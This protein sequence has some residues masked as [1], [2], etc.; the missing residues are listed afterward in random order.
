MS[1]TRD[2]SPE[3]DY[4]EL[5]RRHEEYKARARRPA[6]PVAGQTSEAAQEANRPAAEPK[7]PEIQ[8]KEPVEAP[9]P[10][11]AG[12]RVQPAEEELPAEEYADPEEDYEDGFDPDAEEAPEEEYENPNPF[13]SFIRFFHGVKDK[14]A[15]RHS[16]EPVDGEELPEDDYED[17]DEEVPAK[18]RFGRNRPQPD[19][20][21]AEYDDL[22][23]EE[24]GN[25][26]DVADIQEDMR[27]VHRRAEAAGDFDGED[28]DDAD[29]DGEDF[30]GEQAHGGGF[31]K[32]MRL[33]VTRV[34]DADED[35]DEG[36]EADWDDLEDGGDALY[37]AG[38][39]PA[40][41]G[42]NRQV[43]SDIEGGQEMDEMNKPNSDAMEQLASELESSGMSRRE[44]RER[45]MRLAAE[46]AA[47]KAAQEAAARAAEP[48][49]SQE[50]ASAAT[51]STEEVAE[52]APAPQIREEVVEEP[53]REFK[54]VSM[55]D[56]QASAREDLFDIDDDEDDEED[57]EETKKPRRGLF[58][59]RRARKDE[60]EDEDEDDL[61]D[62]D[63]DEL[64]DEDDEDEDDRPRRGLFGKRRARKYDEDDDEDDLDDEDEDDED[65][66]DDDDEY[67]EYDDDEDEDDDYDDEE[68]DE[69]RSFGHHV[70]GVL[71]SVLGI[72]IFLLIVVIVLNFVPAFNGVVDTLNDKF[73]DSKAFHF[74]FPGYIARENLATPEDV[75]EA[76]IEPTIEPID[77]TD[78]S[79]NSVL[80]DISNDAAGTGDAPE[81]PVEG[82]TTIG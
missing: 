1:N 5:R 52:P 26:E 33:F 40:R 46:E 80:P 68:D 19:F 74:L 31:R 57:E 67:D 43:P 62:E 48:A 37:D 81:A 44:R 49:P 65:D 60:D 63:E 58:G 66:Y 28:L 29:F 13:D 69:H 9:R 22:D 47:R 45:A 17:E 10:R 34:D 42:S 71:K 32:F 14:L 8:R 55:R 51:I 41:P 23:G 25:A 35:E 72:I 53:T 24:T 7:A 79:A 18:R 20:D 64:D 75:P 2:K 6:Q 36:D 38:E 21:E 4:Y 50:S 54:P 82:G 3:L 12:E 11:R 16:E 15:V 56:V 77:V 30:E 70:I 39:S 78:V 76:T 27:P 61:D 59:R 73:G